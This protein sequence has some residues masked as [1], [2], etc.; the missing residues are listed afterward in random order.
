MEETFS[1][2]HM[3]FPL[4]IKDILDARF[5]GI[6]FLSHDEVK[7]GLIFKEGLLCA[8]QSN[9]TEELLGNILVALEII[10]KEEN[11]QSLA[12]ARRERSKQG[13]ILLEMGLVQP[14]QITQALRRQMETRFLDLFTWESGT[15]QQVEKPSITK[16]PEL[17]RHDY[18]QLIRKGIMDLVPFSLVIDSLSS[19]AESRPNILAEQIP[20]DLGIDTESLYEYTVSE[21]LLL[22]QDPARALLALY[23]TGVASFQESK[24][25]NLIDGLRSKL[26][27]L[28]GQDPF[29]TLG[30][31]RK[32]SE[33]G[34]K[35]AYIRIV[36][37]HHPDTYAYA[38]DPE[39]KRL[40]NDI[41][42]EIQRAYN[43]VVKTIEGK[44]ADEP[45]GIDETLQAELLY[46]K[47]MEHL[48]T[49]E[50]QKALDML[51]LCVKMRP[52][53]RLFMESYARAMFLRFQ[54]A[55]IGSPLEI[56]SSIRDGLQRF[57]QSDT[58]YVIWGWVLKKE[59]SKKA[60][61]VFQKAYEINKNN[62]DAQRELR[63]YQIR[64]N[65]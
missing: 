17:S 49:K 61:E 43:T 27:Q 35:R 37:E 33:G 42:M 14:K 23:C 11:E 54:N 51:R 52:E 28:K 56:K 48:K 62:V 41:F 45:S 2:E 36:K 22:G 4:L 10:G 26:K 40:A 24:H 6:L 44:Q 21:L 46:G 31:D 1:L 55:G 34:L 5:S 18:F 63:L 7:K 12:Q 16:E 50:Y 60:P 29:D 3:P 59:G 57:P 38:D 19:F 15:I 32:I 39:V 20:A 13:I 58:L 30:V 9:R 25:K 65:R 53:E 8:I 64:E 47:A